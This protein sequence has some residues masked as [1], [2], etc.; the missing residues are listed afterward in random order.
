MDRD[1]A[2][3]HA[4][5]IW[6]GC[7]TTGSIADYLQRKFPNTQPK[8]KGE[9]GEILDCI[10]K[11]FN[12]NKYLCITYRDEC[13][14]KGECA[15]CDGTGFVL[16]EW[17]VNLA[18]ALSKTSGVGEV[19]FDWEKDF[20]ERIHDYHE[21]GFLEVDSNNC[22]TNWGCIKDFIRYTLSRTLSNLKPTQ[23][24]EEEILVE[25][26]E[27]GIARHSPMEN[28]EIRELCARDIAK[29]FIRKHCQVKG[30]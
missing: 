26:I 8:P 2:E 16:R 1:I 13:S 24:V 7:A 29:S 3:K 11:Y 14:C 28:M 25:E 27:K 19:D 6:E 20:D 15:R 30:V 18:Q 9:V 10:C 23:D 17:V 21:G 5:E 22:I 12:D 4:K